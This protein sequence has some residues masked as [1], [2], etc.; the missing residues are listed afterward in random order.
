MSTPSS[1]SLRPGLLWL[2]FFSFVVYGVPGAALGVAWLE[3]RLDFARTL[4]SLGQLLA[5]MTLGNLL[6]SALSGRLIGRFGLGKTCLGSSLLMLLGLLGYAFSPGWGLLLAATL[7]L[8]LGMGTLNTG[9]NT[10]VAHHYP[11][12]RMSWLHVFYGVGSV[13]GP[14]LMTLLALRAGYSWRLAFALVALAQ[15]LVTA[16]IAAT[17]R[18]WRLEDAEALE[19]SRLKPRTLET[20]R[21]PLAWLGVAFYFVHSGVSLGAGQLT[22]TL[23]VEGRGFSLERAGF[24]VSLYFF[25]VLASRVLLGLVGDRFSAQSILRLSTAA[26]ILGTLLLWWNPLSLVSLL[27]FVLMGFSLATVYPLGISRTPQLVGRS[28]SANAIGLQIAGGAL[29]SAF[30]PWL[31]GLLNAPLGPNVIAVA[32]VVLAVLQFAVHESI[33]RYET[34]R[35]MLAAPS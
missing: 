3:M 17:L 9:V 15:L 21:L 18:D 29:G 1:A 22:G 4:Q 27:G 20:L 10:F 12:S 24:W 16:F 11:L 5:V 34:R 13:I 14:F 26:A 35:R 19:P 6:T 25:C 32:L 28:H 31:I 23:F 7:L 2:A 30:T 33:L 8:G